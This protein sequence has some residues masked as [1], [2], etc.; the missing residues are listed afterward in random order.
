MVL[1]GMVCCNMALCGVVWLG[2]VWCGVVWC[3]VVWCGVVWCGLVWCGVV[4]FGVVWVVWCGVGGVVWCGVVWCG[5]VWCGVVWCGVVGSQL[6]TSKSGFGFQLFSLEK[7]NTRLK[8]PCLVGSFN[9]APPTH[10]R[11]SHQVEQ[12]FV[13]N[14]QI[15]NEYKIFVDTKHYL[16]FNTS[17]KF[18]YYF[19]LYFILIIHNKKFDVA[20]LRNLFFLFS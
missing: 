4:W 18:F 12:R 10:L 2:V 20:I 5:V 17:R 16:S 9:S 13:G 7:A 14:I 15:Q 1:S 11:F 3:G 19:N 6:P 8:I